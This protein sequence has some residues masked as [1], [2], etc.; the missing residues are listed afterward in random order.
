MSEKLQ[1]DD[2]ASLTVRS[3][4]VLQAAGIHSVDELVRRTDTELLSLPGA[5]V[6]M[7]AQIIESLAPH[8]LQL[9]AVTHLNLKR[10]AEACR[11]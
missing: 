4:S 8:D 2:L 3:L 9:A 11:R 5:S 6:V 10:H 7:V 1:L